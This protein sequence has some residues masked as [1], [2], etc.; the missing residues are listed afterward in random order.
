MRDMTPEEALRILAHGHDPVAVEDLPPHLQMRFEQAKVDAAAKMAQVKQEHANRVFPL[1]VAASKST[2]AGKRV[3]WLQ[4]AAQTIG[5]VFGPHAACKSG[6]SHCCHI[7]VKITQAEA[8]YIARLTGHKAAAATDLPPEPVIEGYASPCPFL[9]N[10]QCSIYDRGRPAVCRSHLNMDQDD[11]LCQLIPGMAVPVPFVDTRLL[12]MA[13]QQIHGPTQ[14]M[15]DIR[16]WF[17]S[18]TRSEAQGLQ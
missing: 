13:A 1:L 18:V 14:P 6:C 16:Q 5:D 7:P 9:A 10:D 12:V 4:K 2:T 17:A 15:A 8:Q 3:M 11:L